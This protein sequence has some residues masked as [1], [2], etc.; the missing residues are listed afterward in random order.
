MHKH[1]QVSKFEEYIKSR[2]RK[3]KR[4]LSEIEKR[5]AAAALDRC[6]VLADQINGDFRNKKLR[7]LF[8][9]ISL[10]AEFQ[11]SIERAASVLDGIATRKA[12]G[13]GRAERE[14][15]CPGRRTHCPWRVVI[16]A[17]PSIRTARRPASW[18]ASSSRRR[19]LCHSIHSICSA[20]TSQLA[21]I[22]SN[23]LFIGGF[24]A[25]AADRLASA[26]L[27]RYMSARNDM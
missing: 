27:C 11:V 17:F 2:E 9:N 12:N 26:A 22:S 10:L 25:R 16:S 14:P 21:A 13:A 24:F 8:N 23:A 20:S 1:Q 18:L 19:D 4:A 7:H 15:P 6:R 3:I 5:G